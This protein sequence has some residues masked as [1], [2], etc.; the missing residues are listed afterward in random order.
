VR[1]G[2]GSLNYAAPFATGAGGISDMTFGFDTAGRMVLYYVQ[3]GGGLRK[4]MPTGTPASSALDDLQYVSASA[5]RAYDTGA[6]GIVPVG[7]AGGR[8]VGGTTRHIDLDAPAG[9]R[10]ALVNVT[11]A[12]N[13]GIGFVKV[14]GSRG[15]R[16]PTSSVNADSPASVAANAAIVPIDGEGTFVLEATMSGRIIVDVMG[17]F[18]TTSGPVSEGRYIA[19]TPARLVDTRLPVGT[20][21]PGGSDN[22]YERSPAAGGIGF[23]ARGRNGVPSFITDVTAVVLSIAA[24]GDVANGGYVGIPSSSGDTSIV[25]VLPGDARANLAILP[26]DGTFVRTLNVP[27]IVVDI[28]GYFTGS[29]SPAS[30][31]GLY[32]SVEPVRAVDTR[33]DLGITELSSGIAQTITIPGSEPARAVVQNVTVTRPTGPGYVS[34]YPA[35]AS[36]PLVSTVNFFA[37]QTRPTLAFTTMH[38]TRQVSYEALVPTDLVVDVIGFFSA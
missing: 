10:A 24:I 15:L 23:V 1:S 16:P 7:V 8:V 36:S 17:W 20:A 6:P 9:M 38:E 37:G 22:F 34:T 11:Y 12:D 26:V 35:A 19:L 33:I 30:T 29:S 18:A 4:I 25:N 21:L 27:D 5:V 3:T 14:W 28:V 31:S 13:P 2:D 32:S